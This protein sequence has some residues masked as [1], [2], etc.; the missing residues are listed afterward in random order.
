MALAASRATSQ[1]VPLG[2]RVAGPPALEH[3]H[4]KATQIPQAAHQGL[5]QPTSGFTA[6]NVY[7]GKNTYQSQVGKA[8]KIAPSQP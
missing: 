5:T 2:P 6:S 7:D 4:H 3:L 8:I 1:I